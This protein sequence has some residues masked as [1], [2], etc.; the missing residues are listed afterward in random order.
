MGYCSNTSCVQ[1][2]VFVKSQLRQIVKGSDLSSNSERGKDSGDS[3]PDA[4][5]VWVVSRLMSCL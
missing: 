1:G 2:L 3:S 4:D 5:L